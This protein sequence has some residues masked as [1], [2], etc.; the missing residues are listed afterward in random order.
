MDKNNIEPNKLVRSSELSQLPEVQY[1][2]HAPT[3]YE[4]IEQEEDDRIHILDYWRVLLKRRWTVLAIV[5][6]ATCL[7]VI[8]SW[9]ATPIYQATLRLQIDAEQ[10]N[11]LPFQNTYDPYSVYAKSQEYLQTQFKILES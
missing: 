4:Q 7:S 5:L 9:K 3:L 1:Q 2:S 8:S 10:S 6:T 11:V